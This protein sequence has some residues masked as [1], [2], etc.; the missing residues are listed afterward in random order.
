MIGTIASVGDRRTARDL[1]VLF[2]VATAGSAALFGAALGAMGVSLNLHPTVLELASVLILAVAT[3]ALGRLHLRLRAPSLPRQVPSIWWTTHDR[4]LVA[5][6]WG[7]QLGIGF[8]TY[9]PGFGFYGL[10]LLALVGGPTLGFTIFATFGLVRGAQ[11]ALVV[12]FREKRVASL[13]ARLP[14]L[15]LGA[16]WLALGTVLLGKLY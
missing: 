13:A 4:R 16:S 8:L 1:A 14:A 3:A 10:M 12:L 6:G 9:L 2:L 5:A 15:A 7:A 11:P